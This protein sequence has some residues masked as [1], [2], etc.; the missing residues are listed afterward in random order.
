[1]A[2]KI[3]AGEPIQSAAART[4]RKQLARAVEALDDPALPLADKVHEVR[5][6]I[7]KVR[8]LLRLVR[9]RVGKHFVKPNRKLRD[10]ARKLSPLRDAQVLFDTC[11]RLASAAPHQAKPEFSRILEALAH[12]LAQATAEFLSNRDALPE[13]RKNLLRAR[14]R[15]GTWATHARGYTALGP[16]FIVSYSRARDRMRELAP[17]SSGAQYHEWRKAI[18]TYRYQF[19]LLEVMWPV[20]MREQAEKLEK[21]GELLGHEHDL[22]VLE[23]RLGSHAPGDPSAARADAAQLV[24]PRSHAE[25]AALGADPESASPLR[26]Q[27]REERDR[28]RQQARELAAPLFDESPDELARRVRTYYR[29]FKRTKP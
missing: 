20:A 24:S 6:T 4:A 25:S 26:E 27:L 11:A 17:H 21:L 14:R 19:G 5:T 10:L 29:I 18:K 3:R 16:G 23:S 13:L 15:V 28:L 2:F 7:K 12:Q 22:S 8:A 1:M 9:P